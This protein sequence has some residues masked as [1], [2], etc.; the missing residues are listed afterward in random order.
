MSNAK[1]ETKT[2]KKARKKSVVSQPSPKSAD[3]RSATTARRGLRTSAD[4]CEVTLKTI[5]DLCLGNVATNRAN[6]IFNGVGRMCKLKE[7]E[8]NYAKTVGGKA[9]NTIKLLPA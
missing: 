9:G 5:E 8:M 2:A 3:L 1:T 7:L 6:G 4:L